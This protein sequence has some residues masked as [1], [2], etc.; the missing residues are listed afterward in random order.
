MRR[1]RHDV[2]NLVFL[3]SA[4]LYVAWAA[5]ATGFASADETHIALILPLKSAAFGRAADAVRLGFAAAATMAGKDAPVITIYPADE[6]SANLLNTYQ[7]AIAAGAQLVVGPLT[8][9]GVAAVAA[10]SLISVPTLALNALDEENSPPKF[11][12]FGLSVEFEARQIAK[13]AF[14]DGRRSAVIIGDDSAL[15]KRMHAAFETEFTRLG[16]TI[17]STVDFTADPTALNKLAQEPRLSNADMGF[18]GLDCARA[19]TIRPY[20]PTAISLY[21]TSQINADK[22]PLT[23][24]ELTQVR[25]VDMPWLLQPDHPAVMV[26]PRAQFGDALDFQ[27]LYALGIDAFRIGLE[28]L[29]KNNNPSIDGVTGHIRLSRGHQFVRDLVAAQFVDGNIVVLHDLQP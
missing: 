23:A 19:M 27:R 21:A 29:K 2:P 28:M 3:V 24:H 9:N 6:D 22:A 17:V 26:Y 5:L 18:I 13:L 10:S 4:I 8:R 16:G 25:F 12:T 14:E 1:V 20:L 11:Y 7:Q 15:R